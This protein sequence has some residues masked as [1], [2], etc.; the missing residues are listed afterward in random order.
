MIM[1]TRDEDL[2]QI[3]KEL[4]DLEYGSRR[5]AP[6]VHKPDELDANEGMF[7]W[8]SSERRCGPDCVAFNTDEIDEHGNYLQGPQ[9]CLPLVYLGQQ[10]SAALLKIRMHSKERATLEDQKRAQAMAVSPP[11]V[12]GTKSTR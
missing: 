4:G 12:T 2:D 9:K 10:G 3:E 11:S 6:Y 7:C 8:I 1:P 5:G